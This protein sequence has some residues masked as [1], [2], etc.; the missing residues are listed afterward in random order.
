MVKNQLLLSIALLA[1]VSNV[2]AELSH[3]EFTDTFVKTL[4]AGN[5]EHDVDVIEPLRLEVKTA[6]GSEHAVFLGNAY[7]LYIQDPG[8]LDVILDVYS[9]SLRESVDRPNDTLSEADIVPVIKDD[10]WITEVS[11]AASFSG[12][13]SR[14]EY[15]QQPLVSGLVVLFAEDSPSNIRYVDRGSLEK[16]EVDLATIREKSIENLLR[17]LPEI[18]IQGSDGLYMVVADGN[19]DASLLLVDEIWSSTNF[20]VDGEIVV[21]IPARDTLLVSGT[22]NVKQLAQLIKLSKEIYSESPYYISSNIYVRRDSQ[23]VLFQ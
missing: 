3:D 19:Y 7:D 12:S 23:W 18:E 5:W 22:K 14:P 11:A 8:D 6:D 10:K 20:Q 2:Y 17:K 16:T 21:S 15:Y 1:S 13:K 9:S 4:L